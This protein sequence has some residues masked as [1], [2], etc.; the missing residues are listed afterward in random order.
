MSSS[1]EVSKHIDS[2]SRLE[3]ADDFSV[4]PL[5]PPR[6]AASAEQR[7]ADAATTARRGRRS[8][9]AVRKMPLRLEPGN[10]NMDEGA[11]RPLGA[12]SAFHSCGLS[13]CLPSQ[14]VGRVE[15]GEAEAK[16]S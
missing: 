15:S 5:S 10:G 16:V 13:P 1:M 7:N 8:L 6:K 4:P 14:S 3:D 12:V 9:I 2:G 11:P